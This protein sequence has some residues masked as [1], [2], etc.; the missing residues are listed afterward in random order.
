MKN[1]ITTEEFIKK[2]IIKH[3][4]KYDYQKTQY[5]KLDEKV[6]IICKEHGDF[7]Q[8]PSKHLYGQGCKI[9]GGSHKP[10][11]DEWICKAE[12]IHNNIYDYSKV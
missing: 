11:I 12:E 10:K 6:I 7:W 2:A 9:C 8:L 4:D 1:K 3:G 5:I